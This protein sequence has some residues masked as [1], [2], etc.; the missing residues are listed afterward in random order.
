MP[1][2]HRNDRRTRSHGPY[3]DP[4]SSP[5]F[6]S[7]FG[8]AFHPRGHNHHA[9][10]NFAF[11]DP[12][13]MFDAVFADMERNFGFHAAGP[14]R[15]FQNGPYGQPRPRHAHHSM[16]DQSML[17]F[18]SGAPMF[19]PMNTGGLFDQF[20]ES[21]QDLHRHRSN[22]QR[23]NTVSSGPLWVSEERSMKSVNGVTEAMWRRRDANVSH[24]IYHFL[25]QSSLIPI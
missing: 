7:H 6:D 24:R 14:S 21:P 11:T 4:F 2:P 10:S 16:P 12:F 8:H 15:D 25:V 5:F 3:P 17:G 22:S 19:L 1:Q 18:P 9:P 13:A 20:F 23:R